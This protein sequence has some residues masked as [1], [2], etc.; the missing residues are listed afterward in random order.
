MQMPNSEAAAHLGKA[1]DR[2][3][4][5]RKIVAKMIDPNHPTQDIRSQINRLTSAKEIHT[6]VDALARPQRRG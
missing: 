5:W 1:K 6:A 3:S 4:E 2:L